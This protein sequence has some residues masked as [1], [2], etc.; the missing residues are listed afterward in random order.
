MFLA[1]GSWQ[2]CGDKSTGPDEPTGPLSGTWEGRE[3]AWVFPYDWRFQITDNGGDLRGEY[4]VKQLFDYNDATGTFTGTMDASD[5][6]RITLEGDYLGTY[7]GLASFKSSSPSA[8]GTSIAG[9]IKYGR[10]DE[11]T[12]LGPYGLTL[13]RE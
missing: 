9:V 8:A 11:G 12:E 5:S 1:I 10:D 13:Q 7:R 3:D 6:V 4:G 2:A